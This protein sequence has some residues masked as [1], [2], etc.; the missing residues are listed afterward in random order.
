MVSRK[1][2]FSIQAHSKV[3]PLFASYNNNKKS[4]HIKII[5]KQT[6]LTSPSTFHISQRK[7]RN[8]YLQSL[9]A[10]EG[11]EGAI[12]D[13]LDVVVVERTAGDCEEGDYRCEKAWLTL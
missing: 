8:K 7:R 13:S 2:F 9:D 12:L 11:V 1:V 5:S 4:Y 10:A 6:G 3:I